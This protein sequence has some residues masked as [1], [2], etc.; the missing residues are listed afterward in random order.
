MAKRTTKKSAEKATHRGGR[1]TAYK[2]EYAKEAYEYCAIL[3][4]VVYIVSFKCI[5]GRS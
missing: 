2:P 1:P 5:G 3:N 4:A